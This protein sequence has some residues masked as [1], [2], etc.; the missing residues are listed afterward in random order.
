MQAGEVLASQDNIPQLQSALQAASIP[1]TSAQK[2]YDALLVNV[3]VERANAQLTL[4]KAQKALGT[5]PEGLPQ[6]A[7]PARQ[8]GDH[9]YRPRP[10]DRRQPGPG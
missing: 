10:A 8:P 5:T 2:D 3:P 6:Q 4:V 1:W 7:V 9:R